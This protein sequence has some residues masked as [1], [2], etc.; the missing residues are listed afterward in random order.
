MDAAGNYSAYSNA[1]SFTLPP[2]TT[3]PT[4]PV[5]SLTDV[6]PTHVS[7]A[8]SSIEDGPNI[9]FTVFMNGNLI[10]QGSKKTSATF[11]P[12]EPETTYTFTVQAR[13]FGGNLSPIS[14]PITM[15]TEPSNPN[16]VMPRT[17]PANLGENHWG[18]GE[19]HVSWTQS[20]DDLGEQRFIRYDVYVNGVLS[21]TTV[22]SGFSIV[23]S[24]GTGGLVTVLVIAVDAAGNES[25]LASITIDVDQA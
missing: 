7:L 9:W 23:Y 12:L 4:K 18:D 22:G 1:V 13:D 21:D 2:D 19:I 10:S 14:D 11:V 20:I 17:P 8:W 24:P 6:G 15:T 16:D 5:V 25:A 3:P